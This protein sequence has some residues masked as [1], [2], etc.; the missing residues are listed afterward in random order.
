VAT[1]NALDGLIKLS[2]KEAEVIYYKCEPLSHADIAEKLGKEESTVN[3]QSSSAIRKLGID[4]KNLS[5]DQI[6]LSLTEYY[7]ALQEY[8]KN[9][10]QD[11]KTKQSWLVIIRRMNKDL[12]PVG[13]PEPEKPEETEQIGEEVEEIGE[14]VTEGETSGEVSFHITQPGDDENGNGD[15]EPEEPREPE[16]DDGRRNLWIGITIGVAVICLVCASVGY[17]QRSPIIGGIINILS[18]LDTP[19]EESVAALLTSSPTEPP[20]PQFTIT[21]TSPLTL[22]PTERSAPAG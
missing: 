21:L 14:E 20:L 10:N 11:F 19:P 15:E 5:S 4:T 12:G 3:E 6:I 16:E 22:T 9:P 8:V 13:E 1:K 17:L 18:R 2:A 7:E